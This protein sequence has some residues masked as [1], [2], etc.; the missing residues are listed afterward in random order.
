MGALLTSGCAGSVSRLTPPPDLSA[1]D[2]EECEA[3]AQRSSSRVQGDSILGAAAMGGA[4]GGLVSAHGLARN[5]WSV[6]TGNDGQVVGAVVGSLVALGAIVASGVTLASTASAREAAHVDAM[7]ACLRP[8]LLIR[9]FGPEHSEVAYSLHALG[10]RYYGQQEYAT[11]ER[12]YLRALAIQEKALGPDA[13]EVANILDD[14][15]ALL[16]QTARPL[17][18]IELKQ[19]ARAIRSKR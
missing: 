2:R 9:Q 14:Y 16:N 10:Y 19:R 11:A 6:S 1:A 17:Q 4:A 13:S 7:N 8:A 5:D 18:A 3:L 15:A 12:L